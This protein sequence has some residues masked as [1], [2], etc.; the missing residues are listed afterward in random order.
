MKD[1]GAIQLFPPNGSNQ[2]KFKDGDDDGG[3]GTDLNLITIQEVNNGW[4]VNT[5]FF[6]ENGEIT[7]VTDV[8]NTIDNE[9]GDLDVIKH[10]IHAMGLEGKIKAVENK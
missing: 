6:D 8:F 2:V 1:Q 7:G 10:I 4:L 3:G 9:K 5:E